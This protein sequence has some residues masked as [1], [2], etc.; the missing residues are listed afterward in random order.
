[1]SDFEFIDASAVSFVRRGRKSNID[2]KLVTALK[3][4]K[5]GNAVA[6][7]SMSVDMTDPDFKTEKARISS[8]LRK[9]CELAGLTKFSVRWSPVG[10]PQV[11]CQ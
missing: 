9:A 4:L 8:Q 2:E 3:S 6:I 10:V 5:K 7:K 1:M 11:I